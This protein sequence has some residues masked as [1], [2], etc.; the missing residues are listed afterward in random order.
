M[1]PRT[2]LRFGLRERLLLAFF[3]VSALA[4]LGAGAAIYSFTSIENALAL[5]TRDRVP[6]AIKAQEVSRVTER[7]TAA[8]PTLLTSTS[9]S[10]IDAALDRISRQGNAVNQLLAELRSAGVDSAS[11]V[12]LQVDIGR[13]RDNL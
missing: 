8:A 4:V 9:Q 7:I 2:T 12:A 3:G 6:I 11:L 10:D 13:L 5:I 1:R